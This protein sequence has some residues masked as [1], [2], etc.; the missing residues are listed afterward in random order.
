MQCHF[1]RLYGAAKAD[2]VGKTDYDFVDRKLADSFREDDRMAVIA[3]KSIV[4]EEYLDFAV[5][6]Y[7]GLFEAVK[8]RYT[9]MRASLSVCS[10]SPATSLD[11]GRRKIQSSGLILTWNTGFLSA[12]GNWRTPIRSLKLSVIPC[13]MIANTVAQHRRLQP[14]F[15]T[16]L[17][18]STGCYRE[19]LA[20][21]H[22]PRKPAHGQPDRRHIA[23]FSGGAQPAE[24]ETVNLSNIAENVADELH[25]A[26]P[27][28][29][30][31]LSCKMI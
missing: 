3:G 1:E 22:M 12:R 8:T 16:K 4:D 13:R 29:R 5:G 18:C 19:G 31:G 28:G 30:C 23:S 10:V 24:R 6:G 7:R 17:S 14:G 27:S 21:A 26:F 9:T 2:I 20:G 25:K 15:V 11:T